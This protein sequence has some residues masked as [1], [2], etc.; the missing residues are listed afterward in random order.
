[1]EENEPQLFKDLCL[2]LDTSARVLN[3][4]IK[5]FNLKA[6]ILNYNDKSITIYYHLKPN[7]NVDKRLIEKCRANKDRISIFEKDYYNKKT[8]L[9]ISTIINE[10]I[11]AIKDILQ[12]EIFNYVETR[13][14]YSTTN[15]N[16]EISDTVQYYKISSFDILNRIQI[17]KRYLS[18][19]QYMIT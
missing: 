6:T 14:P 9:E 10:P 4:F 8:I 3:Q 19:D 18:I 15:I 1:M 5:T 12:T 17:K 7:S 2:E 16:M 13:N 11:E